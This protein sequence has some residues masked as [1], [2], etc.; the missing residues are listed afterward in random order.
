MGY[1][2]N[3][4]GRGC[5]EMKLLHVAP[6]YLD[7]PTGPSSS[8]I[9]LGNGL[10]RNGF[11]AALL[12]ACP[13]VG[14]INTLMTVLPSPKV[15]HLNPWSISADWVSAIER[16]FGKPDCIAFHDMYTPFETALARVIR[17]KRG[18]PYIVTPRG[19]LNPLAQRIKGVK[20]WVGNILFNNNFVSNAVAIHALTDEEAQG[21]VKFFPKAKILISPNG[22]S[23][24]LLSVG[25]RFIPAVIDR[26]DNALVL[27]FLGRMAVYC[28]G[29]DLLLKALY[30]IQKAH[31][32]IDIRLLM[33]GCF[34]EANDERIIRALVKALPRP[35]AVQFMGS[36]MGEKKW[37]YMLTGDVFVHTSRFEGMPNAVLEAMALGKPC[38]VTPGTNMGG[39]IRTHAAGWVVDESVDS[40]VEA[41]L[42]IAH[43]RKEII[44]RG[45]KAKEFVRQHLMWDRIA[46]DYAHQLG[47]IL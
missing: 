21:I 47:K 23:E 17:K 45:V 32:D 8:V 37:P 22:V 10:V 13:I 9:E 16:G 14:G 42:E 28:K 36:L 4:Y 31:K 40:I 34:H 20:K 35:Q 6:I 24:D 44:V 38:L 26:G 11:P 43:N 41:I 3:V 12:P 29:I 5:G 33:V 1:I 18:W 39:A 25:Q 46:V 2:E 19:T 15:E 30:K 7:R 27:V